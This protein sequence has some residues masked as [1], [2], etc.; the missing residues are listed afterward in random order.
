MVDTLLMVGGGVV[1]AGIALLFAPYPGKKSRVKIARFGKT[2]SKRGERA[3]RGFAGDLTD[4]ADTVGD[5]GTRVMR[6]V[7]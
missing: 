5:M 7:H 2:V 6:R 1:G 4:F 3:L